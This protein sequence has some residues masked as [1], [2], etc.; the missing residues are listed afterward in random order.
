MLTNFEAMV[1]HVYPD[2]GG[3]PT[4]CVGHVVRPEDHAWIDDGVTIDECR[5]ALVRDV[6]RFEDEL[7]RT[8]TVPLTQPMVDA[9]VSLVF[10]I[11][12]TNWEHSSALRLLNDRQYAAAA[13]AI[14]L[15]RYVRV[16]Q[17]DGTW[18]KKPILL[19]RREAEAK[20]FRSGILAVHGYKGQD[21][22][23]LD[24]LLT[25]AAS[26]QFGLLALLPDHP[27]I[28]PE[29]PEQNDEGGDELSPDGRLVALPP[30]EEEAA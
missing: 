17:K 22:P 23:S 9:L 4:V 21:A 27:A 15:W 1:L 14:T 18:A 19:G 12:E 16:K 8:V 29:T 25:Q 13:D 3:V 2:Q 24:D 6:S 30:D 10:N 7:S 26:F 20:L 28:E 11:G 5:S